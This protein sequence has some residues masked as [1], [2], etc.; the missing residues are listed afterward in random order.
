[1]SDLTRKLPMSDSEQAILTAVQNLETYVRGGIDDLVI[2]VGKIDSRLQRLEQ[3]VEQR[4]YDTRPIW[5]K[6]VDDI[7]KLQAGQQRLEEGQEGLRGEVRELNSAVREVSRDQIV[8]NDVI[9]KL[10]LDF[11]GIDER[12]HRL[13]VNRNQQNSST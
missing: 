4:L 10:H 7:G 1:M 13:E 9:R 12:L 2:W 6:L 3:R 11:H 5:H 8:I